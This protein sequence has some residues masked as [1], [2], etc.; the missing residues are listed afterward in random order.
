MVTLE[1]VWLYVLVEY[2]LRLVRGIHVYQ[3]ITGQVTML[4]VDSSLY[5]T[6]SGKE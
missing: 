1:V 6:I 2:F 5:H 3:L 4:M